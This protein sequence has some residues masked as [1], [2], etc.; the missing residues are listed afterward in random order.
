LDSRAEE[1][2]ADQI[3][4]DSLEALRAEATEK[5]SELQDAIDDI[6]ERLRLATADRFT[7]P[8]IEVPEPEIDEDASKQALVNFDDDWAAATRALIEP[9][10]YGN[11]QS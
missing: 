1:A 9:K 7:L 5:L 6:N 2:L 11:D 3:D 10:A 4:Q 8:A